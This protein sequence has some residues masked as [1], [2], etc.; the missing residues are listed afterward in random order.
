MSRKKSPPPPR[1]KPNIAN[2]SL[3]SAVGTA[4]ASDAPLTDEEIAAIT[5]SW[6][7][8]ARAAAEAMAKPIVGMLE[9]GENADAVTALLHLLTE[10]NAELE[11]ANARLAVSRR[12]RFGS[13]SERLNREEL[14]QAFLDFGGQAGPD[15][16][17]PD[18]LTLTPPD[19]S[20]TEVDVAP[21]PSDEEVSS[22]LPEA[23][24]TSP[25]TNTQAEKKRRGGGRKP[26]PRDL[27]LCIHNV[28]I[29]EHERACAIC[30]RERDAI[31]QRTHQWLEYV[32]AKLVLHEE[33]REILGCRPCRTDV[34]VADRERPKM[35]VRAGA[36]V[37]AHMALQKC[38]DAMPLERQADDWQRMGLDIAPSTM[39]RWWTYLCL[40]LT[41]LADVIMGRILADP[42]LGV[43][44]TGL[45]FLDAGR[46]DKRRPMSRGHIWCFIGISKLVGYRFT[47][48]WRADDIAVH[49]RLA[50]GFVQGDGY[51]GYD[52]SVQLEGEHI[53]AP[54]VDPE[55]KLGCL[56]HARRPFH[57]TFSTRDGRAAKPL[58]YFRQLYA[59]EADFKK[60]G[61]DSE[62]RGVA[63]AEQ[64][65]P[66]FERLARWVADIHPKLRPTDPLTK[67]TTYFTNQ[68]PYL[69]RLFSSGLFE[70]D[71]SRVERAIREFVVARKAFGLTGSADAGA[72]LAAVF[73]IVESARRILPPTQV[74]AY[75]QD[76]ITRLA[77]GA[78]LTS[79]HDLVPD[80]WAAQHPLQ[81]R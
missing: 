52:A 49:L 29:P 8:R 63:R 22:A 51:A 70:L 57:E 4:A 35:P 34:Q 36:S 19:A 64:S 2:P 62:A 21:S 65:M 6:T 80:V 61:L 73:T 32:P 12:L 59:L 31:F 38:D 48:T 39:D 69:R 55:R 20:A 5:S 16:S 42:Y 45:K 41:P 54:V 11:R 47:E 78:E 40:L 77:N 56:M 37:L 24:A 68:E 33:R 76:V 53:S 26:F 46:E 27:P 44:D 58:E 60:R 79:L 72:R 1:S 3:V 43:D 30:G 50:T 13:S 9:R 75:L 81:E 18:A 71:T 25:E 23:A 17:L 14:E 67:A 74:R 66:I 7:R 28:L 10:Q 15:G